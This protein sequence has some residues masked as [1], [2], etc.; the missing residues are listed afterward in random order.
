V[1]IAQ[2][3]LHPR[4]VAVQR[5]PRFKYTLA[6][7]E[8]NILPKNRSRGVAS[9]ECS[10]E[11]VECFR[12]SGENRTADI[13]VSAWQAAIVFFEEMLGGGRCA[14]E[15]LLASSNGSNKILIGHLHFL[16]WS[17]VG[18]LL[19]GSAACTKPLK[20]KGFGRGNRI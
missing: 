1:L 9:R 4:I 13:P 17:S 3:F 6:A 11:R 20:T 10:K 7:D 14:P 19:G 18:S 2:E 16:R 15:A 5:L 8:F 12:L